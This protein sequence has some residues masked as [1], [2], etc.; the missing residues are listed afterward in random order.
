MIQAITAATAPPLWRRA[1]PVPLATLVLAGTLATSTACGSDQPTEPNG[2]PVGHYTL[3]QV[4]RASLPA[5]IHRG[6]WFDAATNHFYNQLILAV[7]AGMLELKADD[8]FNL[9]FDLEITGDGQLSAATIDVNG[10]YERRSYGVLLTP[11][12]QSF[13][14]AAATFRS[15]AL[16]MTIDFVGKGK[17]NQYSFSR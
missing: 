2:S 12:E 3:S 5:T 6:P 8:R 9:S 10:T 17:I 15:T 1:A 16:T 11:D 4:D 14:V 13:G 7:T